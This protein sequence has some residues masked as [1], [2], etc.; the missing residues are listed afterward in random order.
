M[1]SFVHLLEIQEMVVDF[2]SNF[3]IQYIFRAI[4][5]FQKIALLILLRM[6]TLY[7]KTKFE[8]VFKE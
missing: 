2:L 8:N 7:V 4:S 3:L 5:N 1:T 6:Y